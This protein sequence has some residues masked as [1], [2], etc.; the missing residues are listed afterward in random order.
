MAHIVIPFG[1]YKESSAY[2]SVGGYFERFVAG[3]VFRK[4]HCLKCG[5]DLR[6][7]A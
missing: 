3:S 6:A 5:Y 7:L 2:P 1:L 4:A